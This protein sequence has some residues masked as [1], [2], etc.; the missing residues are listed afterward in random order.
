MSNTPE[1]TQAPQP[2]SSESEFYAKAFPILAKVASVTAVLMYVFYFPQI[3]G[4]L[5]GSKGDWIQPLVAAV[6]CTLWVTYGLWRPAGKRDWP[7][8]IAN[9]PG[10]LFGSLAAITALI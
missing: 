4:N 6:N 10:I 7:I 8:V 3:I 2:Q 1:N 9:A 5:N